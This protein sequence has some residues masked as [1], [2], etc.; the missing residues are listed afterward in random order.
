M[1]V[2]VINLM[3]FLKKQVV[4]TKGQPA[5]TEQRM[6]PGLLATHQ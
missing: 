1:A 6:A 5:V 3:Y 4:L 2:P